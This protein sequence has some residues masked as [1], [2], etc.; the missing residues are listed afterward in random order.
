MTIRTTNKEI[1]VYAVSM[2]MKAALLSAV[3][4]RRVR[5]RGL[6]SIAKLSIDEKDKEI[7]FL[8]YRIYHLKSPSTSSPITEVSLLE[9]LLGNT[10]IQIK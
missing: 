2:I 3:W 1:V 8:R 7:V 6:E 4:T 9:Q 10:S 5:K